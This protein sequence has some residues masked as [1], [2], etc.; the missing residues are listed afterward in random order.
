MARRRRRVRAALWCCACLGLFLTARATYTWRSRHIVHEPD[1]TSA[2]WRLREDA[3][4]RAQVLATRQ[5]RLADLDLTRSPHDPA[6]FGIEDDVRCQYV[7]KRTTATSPKFDC[8]LDSGEVIKVKYNTLEIQAEVAGTRLFAALGFG[9]D[10]LS[11]VRRLRCLGCPPSPF[12]TR[13]IFEYF[14]ADRLL[15]W[16]LDPARPRDFD[17]VAIERKMPGRAFEIDGFEGWQYGELEQID[18]E[19]GGASRAEVD[20]LRL[21][22]IL[23]GHWDNKLDNQRVICREQDDK[24]SAAPCAEPLLMV[25]DLGSTFGARRLD[26]RA[27]REQVVWN[28][29]ATCEVSLDTHYYGRGTFVPVRISERGRLWT[30]RRLGEL[31]RPQIAALFTGA[32]FPDPATGAI[33]SDPTPWVDAFLDKVRQIADRP[34]CPA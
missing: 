30:A 15:D 29:A 31:S 13:R 27:W 14:F 18:P 26:L 17:W 3:I 8:R 9:A 24:A 28:D 4:S 33:P 11:I 12:R 25:H 34:P 23:V 20:G 6:P 7:P 32:R 16:S 5:P 21:L 2:A 22:T 1:R 10:R 19:R